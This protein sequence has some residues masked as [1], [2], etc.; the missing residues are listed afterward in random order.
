[1]RSKHIH[2]SLHCVREQVNKDNI[3]MC[4][5]NTKENVSDILTK[6]LTRVDHRRLANRLLVLRQGEGFVKL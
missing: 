4:Y 2:I 3:A 1:M 5:I 6:V